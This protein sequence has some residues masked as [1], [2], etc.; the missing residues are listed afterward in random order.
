[1]FKIMTLFK[2]RLFALLYVRV[3]ILFTCGKHLYDHTISLRREAWA[4][5]T[6]F[7]PPPF[8]EVPVTNHEIEWLYLCVLGVSTFHLP[9]IYNLRME[10]FQ[11][12]GIFPFILLSL[13]TPVITDNTIKER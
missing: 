3:D 9:T 10:Q 7:T 13:L 4:N 12:R 6:S 2:V 5:K 8:I 11:Q 1:M